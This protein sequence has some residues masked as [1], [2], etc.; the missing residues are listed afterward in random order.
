MGQVETF[1]DLLVGQA[2]RGERGDLMFLRGE[3]GEPT[4]VGPD[5]SQSAGPQFVTGPD[6]PGPGPER[7]EGAEGGAEVGAGLGGGP[8]PAQVLAVR[9]LNPRQVK[10]PA[11]GGGH[12]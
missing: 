8:G 1:A 4:A 6:R 5:D 2:R 7:F 9:Q 10:R 3:S 11:V 12:A